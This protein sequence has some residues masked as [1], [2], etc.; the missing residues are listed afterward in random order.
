[1]RVK[2]RAVDDGVEPAVVSGE[3]GDVGLLEGGA[4]QP[5]L[6]SRLGGGGDGRRREVDAMHGVAVG[7]QRQ[8]Q[9]RVAASGVEDIAAELPGGGQ[10]GQLRLRLTDVPGRR[11]VEAGLLAVCTVPVH[12]FICHVYQPT[13][14]R[15]SYG[16]ARWC[17]CARSTTATSRPAPRVCPARA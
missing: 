5:A 10:R 2:Q 15:A 4:A 6:L 14:A 8:R 11:P 7:G 1:Q 13:P 9:L 16:P 3:R 17:A 12:Y